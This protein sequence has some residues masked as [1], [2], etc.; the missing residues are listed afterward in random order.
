MDIQQTQHSPAAKASGNSIPIK[1]SKISRDPT[2]FTST[3]TTTRSNWALMIRHPLHSAVGRARPDLCRVTDGIAASLR[4]FSVSARRSNPDENGDGDRKPTNRQR[5]AAAVNEI[6]SMMEDNKSPSTKTFTTGSGARP[7][8][9]SYAPPARAQRPNIITLNNLRSGGLNRNSSGPGASG[10]R[11]IRGGFR[12]RGRGGGSSFN[13]GGA[14]RRGGG[15][16]ASANRDDRPRRSRPRAGGRGGSR[17][18]REDKEGEEDDEWDLNEGM[19]PA[20]KAYLEEKEMG[21]T[22]T[23]NPTLTLESLT[24]WGPAVATSGTPFGQGEVVMRQARILGGGHAFHPQHL[25]L[26]DD[27][28]AAYRDGTGVFVPPSEEAKQWTR[29][30]LKDKPITAPPEVKTAILE[31][32]LLGKYDGP[33]YADPEDTTGT[34]RSYVKRDGTWNVHAERNIEAKVQTLLSRSQPAGAAGKG[35][36]QEARPKA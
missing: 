14:M 17:R 34:V 6:I 12:G 27:I 18:R 1:I 24:G 15:G 30:V 19:D 5:S 13:T 32:A 26:P 21:T 29:Q 16:G 22:M 4:Q 7:E 9:G 28:R 10:P 23:F 31:D 3:P 33:K 20:V 8:A 11:I 35:G 36:A 2:Q 25:L